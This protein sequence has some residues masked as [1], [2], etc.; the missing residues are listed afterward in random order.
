[1]M[2]FGHAMRADGLEIW[3]MLACG[4]GSRRRRP[5]KRWNGRNFGG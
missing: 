3:M 5:R 4:D 1:M 2:L